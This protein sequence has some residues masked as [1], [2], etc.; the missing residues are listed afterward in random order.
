MHL[1]RTVSAKL[2]LVGRSGLPER[3]QWEQWLATH[4]DDPI[5]HK[6]QQVRQLEREGAEVLV[7]GADVGDEGQMRDAIARAQNRFGALNGAIHAAGLVGEKAFRSLSETGI[8]ECQEQ[9]QAKVR[10]L[11]VLERVLPGRGLD[12]CILLSSLASILGGLGFAAYSAA[13]HFMDAFAHRASAESPFPWLSV[14]WDGWQFH[15]R[16]PSQSGLGASLQELA[17]TPEDGITALARLLSLDRIPQAIV[18]TGDLQARIERWLQFQPPKQTASPRPQSPFSPQTQPPRN[19]IEQ[20]VADIW[21]EFLGVES[22]GVEDN[23]FELGGHSLLATQMVSHLRQIFQVDLPLRQLF[24]RPTV[25]GLAEA[26]A[27]NSSAPTS[28][29]TIPK[30]QRNSPELAPDDL[31]RLPDGEVDRLLENLLLAQND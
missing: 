10:G 22:V 27:Q 25:A 15:D 31:D 13:N 30:I 19:E 11:L 4:Q 2:I 28:L 16:A 5:S 24:E 7:L 14:N 8:A 3:S 23:F 26:I 21:Q 1:A 6:I 12:F 17:L 20:Q 18:S 29:P 9:F